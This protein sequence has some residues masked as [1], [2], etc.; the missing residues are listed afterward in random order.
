M[1]LFESTNTF[2]LNMTDDEGILELHFENFGEGFSSEN[3][4]CILRPFSKLLR[5]GKPIGRINYVF[6]EDQ[7]GISYNLGTICLSP[8]PGERLIFFPGLNDRVLIWYSK[9]GNQKRMPN[10]VFIDHFSLEKNL[11]SWHLT[12]LG[13]AKQKTEKIPK[14]RTKKWSE[15]TIFWFK[16]SIQEPSVLE[17]T[18]ETIKTNFHLNKSE[19]ERR[20]DIIIKARENAVW[21]ITK[22]HEDSL[23]D[24]GDFL[25]FEFY[26]GPDSGIDPKLLPIEDED[27][28]APYTGLK[29][30]IPLRCHPVTLE[31]FPYKIWVITYKLKG[32]LKEKAI[33]TAID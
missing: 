12:L 20:K 23:L 29:K 14:M 30:N 1:K 5:G 13:T 22:L 8:P 9:R 21:H 15:Q 2:Y 16:L 7:D 4:S 28:A 3:E 31:G 19:W 10:K 32:R 18:P 33:I 11:L 24:R 27:L 25:N 6:F 17:P 26:L